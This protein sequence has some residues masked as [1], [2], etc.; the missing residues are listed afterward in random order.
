[1]SIITTILIIFAA[2]F[3]IFLFI[4]LISF[5]I[6]LKFNKE[7]GLFKGSLEIRWFKIRIIHK[8]FPEKEKKT[9]EKDVDDEKESKTPKT[10]KFEW[11]KLKSIFPLLKDAGPHIFKLILTILNSISLEKIYAHFI[12]GFNSPADTAQNIGYFWAVS[13]VINVCPIVNIYAE[14]TF[15]QEKI[16]FKSHILFKIRLFKPFIK[17]LQLFTKKSVIKLIWEIRRFK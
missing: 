8:K 15:N 13:S 5:N 2:V 17:L 6:S 10:D 12:L 7:G 9:I 16:D 1:M 14:P 4:L 3:A 11:E